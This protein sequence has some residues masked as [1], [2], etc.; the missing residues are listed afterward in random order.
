MII[1]TKETCNGPCLDPESQRNTGE[2]EIVD[3]LTKKK[4]TAQPRPHK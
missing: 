1:S 4:A 3:N 2:N